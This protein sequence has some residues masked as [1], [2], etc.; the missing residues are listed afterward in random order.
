[1]TLPLIHNLPGILDGLLES[2]CPRNHFIP[3]V[4]FQ[5]LTIQE[6]LQ[7]GMFDD[8]PVFPHD[9]PPFLIN[10]DLQ[11]SCLRISQEFFS[12]FRRNINISPFPP[13]RDRRRFNVIVF[14]CQFRIVVCLPSLRPNRLVLDERKTIRPPRKRRGSLRFSFMRAHNINTASGLCLPLPRQGSYGPYHRIGTKIWRIN[15]PSPGAGF[16]WHGN[17]AIKQSAARAGQM[18]P[19]R[20]A[21][22]LST[23][24]LELNR[25]QAEARLAEASQNEVAAPAVAD[26]PIEGGRV[27]LELKQERPYETE[28]QREQQRQQKMLDVQHQFISAEAPSAAGA[29]TAE[30][31]APT[32]EPTAPEAGRRKQAEAGQ[33]AYAQQMIVQAAELQAGQAAAKS[34]AEEQARAAAKSAAAS[35]AAATEDF[36]F[37]QQVIRIGTQFAASPSIAAFFT[38]LLDL[39]VMGAK[40]LVGSKV[41]IPFLYTKTSKPHTGFLAAVAF[42]DIMIFASSF[43]VTGLIL[44]LVTT[45]VFAVVKFGIFQIIYG[46]YAS[47][48]S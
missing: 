7:R 8:P 23:A 34:A 29:K 30:E 9:L 12:F 37:K 16:G 13:Y 48:V 36:R 17:Q 11:S 6:K 41:D 20:L 15:H 45:L 2:L 33:K 19:Q 46:I 40:L 10:A 14:P 31:V 5:R 42:F 26:L 39:N 38:G 32:E 35:A 24:A 4:P 43:I 28:E 21:P 44:I 22:T 25:Q 18:G 27:F 1:M 47:L 3:G